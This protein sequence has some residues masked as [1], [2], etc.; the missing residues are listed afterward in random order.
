MYS[1]CQSPSVFQVPSTF[2]NKRMFITLTIYISEKKRHAGKN[3]SE[4]IMNVHVVLASCRDRGTQ[5]AI[6]TV[7]S[8]QNASS[9][10]KEKVYAALI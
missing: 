8:L 3:V 6:M 4:G 1:R 9:R 5:D 7:K 2:V 10:M